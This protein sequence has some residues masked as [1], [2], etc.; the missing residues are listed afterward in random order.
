MLTAMTPRTA[1]LATRI[2]EFMEAYVYP[3]EPV[4]VRQLDA[5]ADRA[6]G[7]LLRRDQHP[8]RDQA[9]RRPLRHQR[10]QMVDIGRDGP[11]LQDRDRDG[12][13]RS[14]RRAV[15][16]PVDGA[17]AARYAWCEGGTGIERVR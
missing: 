16:A 2:A 10:P 7:R 15:P 4:F 13:H 9:R 6:G 14:G 17:G 1:E 5:A 12:A 3:A 11:P 8:R